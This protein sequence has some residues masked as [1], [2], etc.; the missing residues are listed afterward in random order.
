MRELALTGFMS[1]RGRQVG[2]ERAEGMS[3][4]R[5]GETLAGTCSLL[6][7][8]FETGHHHPGVVGLQILGSM[9]LLLRVPSRLSKWL[10]LASPQT[11]CSY[12]AR[13]SW[14]HA[15][16]WCPIF[17]PPSLSSPPPPPPLLPPPCFRS[18]APS[19]SETWAWTGAWAPSGLSR[20]C[21]TSTRPPTTATGRTAQVGR[22]T[23]KW[24]QCMQQE[25]KGGRLSLQL[26]QL[27]VR[28]RWGAQHATGGCGG[29]GGG[30]WGEGEERV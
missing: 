1:N 11:V 3:S 25:C 2:W 20:C 7:G 24:G 8:H 28:R 6:G 26:R 9:S 13:G 19:S 4:A 12:D 22:A 15:H 30:G 27:D 18:F 23:C 14:S 5:W 17:V 29:G 10:T 21:S 16:L